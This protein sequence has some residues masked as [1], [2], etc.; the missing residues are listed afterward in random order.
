MRSFLILGSILAILVGWLFWAAPSSRAYGSVFAVTR[1]E[2]QGTNCIAYFTSSNENPRVV[3]YPSF[4]CTTGPLA[5][6]RWAEWEQNRTLGQII[7]VDPIMDD[8]NWMRCTV[9]INGQVVA[10]DFAQKSDRREISCLRTV[11]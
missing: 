7:G 10:T 1:V 9:W 2:W 5:S 4:D 8:N 3:G 11:R 6:P